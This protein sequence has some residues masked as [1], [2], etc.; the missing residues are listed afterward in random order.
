MELIT[1]IL[2]GLSTLL[3]IGPVFFYLVKTTL[4]GGIW[5]GV[6]VAIDVVIGDVI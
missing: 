6:S 4:E 2:L 3:F 5:A 1:G